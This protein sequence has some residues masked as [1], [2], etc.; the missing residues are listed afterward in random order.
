MRIVYGPVP[1]R[2]LGRSLG[3][4]HIPPKICSYARVYCQLGNTLKLW[5][6]REAFYTPE[7][8]VAAV[9]KAIDTAQ[10]RKESIDYLAFVP[11]GEPTLDMN[12]G[13]TMHRLKEF[14]I[15]IAVITNGSLI[16]DTQ[17][18]EELLE[19][20]WVSLKVDSVDKTPWQKTDRP[21]GKLKLKTILE[22]ML[23]FRRIFTGQLVTETMLIHQYNDSPDQ[24]GRT[25]RFL[26]ELQ[27]DI[28]YLSIPTRPPAE[29]AIEAAYPEAV[30]RYWQV[31]SKYLKRVEVLAGYVGNTFAATGNAEEDILSFTSVH[32]MRREAINEL[33]AKTSQSW[34]IVDKLLESGAIVELSYGGH[35][36][37][38]RNF[39]NGY[40]HQSF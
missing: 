33:L 29:A 3:I 34:D 35:S 14:Q 31:F 16:D 26:R 32:P 2:R 11:D 5:T 20:D 40:I 19:A 8:I 38:L 37:F 12:L 15:P 7:V 25:V 4:N 13:Q 39:K 1:S 10:K 9:A 21:H 18:R 6:T 17:V 30:K 28:A 36:Y 23:K 24:A 22:G 27:P